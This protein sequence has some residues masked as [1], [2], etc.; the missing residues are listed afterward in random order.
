MSFTSEILRRIHAFPLLASKPKADALTVLA[1]VT[2]KQRYQRLV[3]PGAFAV[4]GFLAGRLSGLAPK[5]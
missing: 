1:F 4:P 3:L 5:I 2:S